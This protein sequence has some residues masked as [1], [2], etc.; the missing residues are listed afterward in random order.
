MIAIMIVIIMIVTMLIN[1]ETMIFI[2]LIS[3]IIIITIIT[4][5]KLFPERTKR[6]N[7]SPC[8]VSEIGRPRHRSSTHAAFGEDFKRTTRQHWPANDAAVGK[9]RK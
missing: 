8:Y 9:K 4:L 2:V 5:A 6:S 3:S 7:R 1:V